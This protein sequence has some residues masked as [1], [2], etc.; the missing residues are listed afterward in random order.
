M[1]TPGLVDPRYLLQEVMREDA[2][3][4][5]AGADLLIY[6]V[7]AGYAPSIEH[8]LTYSRAAGPPGLLCLNK[9]DRITSD[10]RGAL[11]ARFADAGWERVIPTVATSGE[12]V[13]LLM[14]E[15]LARLPTSPPLYPADD[16]AVAPLRYFV[17][18]LIRETVFERLS[19]EVPYSSAVTVE[20]FREPEE[21]D[22]L[23]YIEAVI[24]VE[25]ESQKGIVIGSAGKRIRGI[26][27]ASREKI[28]GFLGRRIYLDLRVKVLRNWRKRET[29][30]NLL[31]VGRPKPNG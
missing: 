6:V 14:G 1:D 26:G 23:V 7:D 16:L 5:I 17:A 25:R 9:V 24:H 20:Q 31:G 22:G 18:E 4:A 21:E 15:A 10:A 13:A 29:A 30:L 27:Q 28:E 12:G 3:A 19:D 11:E 8:G 2:E